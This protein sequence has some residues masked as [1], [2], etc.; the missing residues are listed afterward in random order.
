M[1]G[2]VLRARRAVAATGAG[3]LA[4]GIAAISAA[5]AVA[6]SD[7]IVVFKSAD[8]AVASAGDA[9]EYEVEI[10]GSQL[11]D[12]DKL[13]SPQSI[14]DLFEAFETSDSN[15][16]VFDDVPEHM[17]VLHGSVTHNQVAYAGAAHLV[18]NS[19]GGGTGWSGPWVEYNDDNAANAG[20]V[21]AG[22]LGLRLQDTDGGDG[23][24][25][26]IQRTITPP[27][28]VRSALFVFTTGG[29]S[30]D[31]N[32]KGL[33]EFSFDG[34]ATWPF[35]QAFDGGTINTWTIPVENIAGSSITMRATAT[36]ATF[37]TDYLYVTGILVG[38]NYDTSTTVTPLDLDADLDSDGNIDVGSW[39][40]SYGD[41][42]YLTY[43][44]RI[45]DVI[46]D[47]TPDDTPP[48]PTLQLVNNVL[49]TS[50]DDP[51]GEAAQLV[52]DL[53]RHPHFDIDVDDNGPVKVGSPLVIT[54]AVS[55]S[56]QS[57]GF[58]LCN[59]WVKADIEPYDD[60]LYVEGDDGDN[61]LE[62]S[63]TWVMTRTFPGITD[64]SGLTGID[65]GLFG[66]GPGG[67]PYIQ[68]EELVFTV[69]LAESGSDDVSGL[70]VTVAG[71]I[72]SGVA[73]LFVRTRRES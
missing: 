49:V 6:D 65:I 56:E 1:F 70:L 30:T 67:S 33:V 18:A 2:S 21:Q 71:L 31:V 43:T 55:H 38:Y 57:D 9:V 58:P 20:Q 68:M 73:L 63:E 52:L 51:A 54:V 13:T 69:V 22:F 7:D 72:A 46:A 39:D 53:E 44:A 32:D 40:I 27:G 34:G 47:E 26:Y 66:D 35:S 24:S 64:T 60:F 19:Y 8:R 14:A 28:T 59:P 25:P 42:V 50:D 23:L 61:C 16:R 62:Y 10:R 17:I 29:V 48:V 5:P 12:V 45:A 15:V 3:A 37:V 11:I 4:F 36:S 41:T